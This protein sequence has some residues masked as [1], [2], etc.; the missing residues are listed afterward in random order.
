MPSLNILFVSLMRPTA[1]RVI[2]SGDGD[3]LG[4]RY[5]TADP[6]RAEHMIDTLCRYL[7]PCN[8]S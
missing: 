5:T 7:K 2:T 8:I 1:T 3:Q 4:V 6:Y